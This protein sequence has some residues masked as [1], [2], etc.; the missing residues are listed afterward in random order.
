L[1]PISN[2]KPEYLTLS[3]MTNGTLTSQPITVPGDMS[4]TEA[5]DRI[6]YR[7]AHIDQIDRARYTIRNDLA[8]QI[9]EEV[10]QEIYRNG[11]NQ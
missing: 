10:F 8:N 6:R 7:A 5:L 1:H 11:N 4:L 2:D 3:N 9:D